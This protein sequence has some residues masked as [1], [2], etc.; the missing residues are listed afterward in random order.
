VL[1]P[2]GNGSDAGVAE[3]ITWAADHGAEIISL[4][5]GGPEESKVMKDAVD[6]AAAKGTLVVAAM[7]NAGN[8]EKSYPAA[9]PGVLAVGATDEKD[10]AAEFSQYGEWIS[11]SA[12]GVAIYSTFPTYKVDMNEYGYPQNYAA[13]DGTSMATP[14]VAGLAALVKSMYPGLDAAGIRKRIEKSADDRGDTGFDAHFGHGRVNALRA[15]S[16]T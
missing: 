5:L 2:G 4:S 3:G 6:Y 11:V 15:L 10:E 13:L 16:K 7:G 9:Y 8:G 12:P 14:A 1:G